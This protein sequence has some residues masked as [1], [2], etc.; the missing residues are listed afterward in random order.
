MRFL[1]TLPLVLLASLAVLAP[2]A[3][4]PAAAA[5]ALPE[6]RALVQRFLTVTKYEVVAKSQSRHEKG[7]LE[8][9]VGK[10]QLES[11]SVRPL[12][13]RQVTKLG[14]F[15]TFESGI[16]A[17]TAWMTL[18]GGG[19]TLLEGVELLQVRLDGAYDAATKPETLFQ[20]LT[21][22]GREA[23]EGVEC[24]KVEVVARPLEGMDVEAT[25]KA[26]TFHEFY[27]VESGLLRGSKG[28]L[29]GEISKGPYVR[30]FKDYKELAGT[31]VPTRTVLRQ[32]SLEVVTKLESIDF[33]TATA[34]D[35]AAPKA[36]QRLLAAEAAAK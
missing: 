10:G 7:T 13:T 28:L 26:R 22:V 35:L 33:D 6:A 4:E 12:S 16:L 31:L 14:D 18:P 17:G 5:Q 32:D 8:L 27:E 2:S 29:E 19:A 3:Q 36:I 23:F 21:T 30:I 24:F 20:S 11:W 9:P 15:G 25:K 34:A 1:R